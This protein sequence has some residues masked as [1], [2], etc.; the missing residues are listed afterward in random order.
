MAAAKQAVRRKPEPGPRASE[1]EIA[2]RGGT[3]G[4]DDPGLE[5]HLGYQGGGERDE[6]AQDLAD[7]DVH[8]DVGER[9]DLAEQGDGRHEWGRENVVEPAE[10][11]FHRVQAGVGEL[12]AQDQGVVDDLVNVTDQ[13]G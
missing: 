9:E 4:E 5:G 8:V 1:V 2:R 3:A 11:G 6:H 13:V 12:V 7:G 10:R